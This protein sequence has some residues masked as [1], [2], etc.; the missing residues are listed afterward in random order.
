MIHTGAVVATKEQLT[1]KIHEI[2]HEAEHAK[3]QASTLQ[4]CL[5]TTSPLHL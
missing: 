5:F 3:E 4:V 2:R 1:E